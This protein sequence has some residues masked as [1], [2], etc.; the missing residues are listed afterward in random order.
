MHLEPNTVSPTTVWISFRFSSSVK[1]SQVCV[2]RR[3]WHGAAPSSP[4]VLT[5][6]IRECRCHGLA[7]VSARSFTASSRRPHV[8]HRARPLAAGL[9]RNQSRQKRKLIKPSNHEFNDRLADRRRTRPPAQHHQAD[10][11]IALR[12]PHQSSPSASQFA[13]CV[14]RRPPTTS[15][16]LAH[17]SLPS[18]GLAGK[19][20]Q[21]AAA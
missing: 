13:P 16:A 1:D 14:K 3:Q 4:P 2:R 15:S 17:A 9:S 19:R 7:S 10:A 6:H 18:L 8:L 20:L 12:I 5:T 11:D 21:H